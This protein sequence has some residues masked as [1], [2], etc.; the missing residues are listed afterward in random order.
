MSLA[1]V[2]VPV[3]QENYNRVARS[4]WGHLHAE[5]RK[6]YKGYIVFALTDY[7]E[8]IV[9]KY[10]FKGLSDSPWLAQHL[11][12]YAARQCFDLARKR[13]SGVYRFDGTYMVY[14][15]GKPNFSG[16]VRTIKI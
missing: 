10:N 11:G 8:S 7:N 15:N 1:S 4:T 13:H 3:E 5:H 12:D 6:K 14:Y 2:F 9:I 16:K